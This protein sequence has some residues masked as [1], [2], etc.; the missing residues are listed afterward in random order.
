MATEPGNLTGLRDGNGAT[1]SASRDTHAG[2]K[3]R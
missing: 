1:D 2:T 3:I